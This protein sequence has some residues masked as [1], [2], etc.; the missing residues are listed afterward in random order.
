MPFRDLGIDIDYTGRGDDILRGFVLPVLA[1]AI[2]YDRVTSFFSTQSLIAIAAGLDSLWHRHGRMRLVL[3]IHNVPADL[4]HAARKAE[5]PTVLIISQVRQ[6]IIEGIATISDELSIDRL[7]TVAWMMKDSLLSVKV[8]SP[9]RFGLDSPGLFH[10]KVFIFRDDNGDVVA[11]VGSPN[12]TGAGLG[13]NFEHLTAFTSWEQAR[14]TN[15]QVNFFERLWANEQDGLKVHLLDAT[16]ADQILEA[17][18]KARPDFYYSSVCKEKTIRKLLDVASRM[19]ALSMVAGG[20]TALYPHQELVFLDGLSRWPVRLMLADEV[21]LGKTFEAGAILSYMISH[22]GIN[23]ILVLAPK[24]VVFQWQAELN[25]HFGLDSWVYESGRRAFVSPNDEVVFLGADDPIL[26]PRTPRIV[27]V[28]SQLARGTR[29]QGHIFEN[30]SVLPDMMVV[31]EAHAARVKPDLAGDERPTLLWKMLADVVQKVPHIVFATAT[32]MQVHWREYHALLE[33]LG[34]PDEWLK[35]KQYHRSLE[36]TTRLD[37][38]DLSEASL[39]ARLIRASLNGYRPSELSLSQEE[40]TLA[41]F[42]QESDTQTVEVAIRV[43]REWN[44]ARALLVKTHPA[45]FLTLRNTRTALEAIDYTFPKRNLPPFSLDVPDEVK[46]FY[47]KVE[48]YLSEVYFEV[49]RAL[50]PDRKFS[51][52]F[53]KCAYQQRLASSLSACR[54]SLIHRRDRVFEIEKGSANEIFLE[55]ELDELTESDAFDQDFSFDHSINAADGANLEQAIQSARIERLFLDD[56]IRILD[57][58]I[59]EHGDP[60]MR[61]TVGLLHQHLERGDKVLVFSRYTDTLD[62]VV[63]AFCAAFVDRCPPYAV[64]TG[65]STGIDFG[66][67]PARATRGEIRDA[68]EEGAVSVVFC[69]DAASEGLNLQA[70]R[71]IVNVD[72]PWN[73][74][75]LEQRIGRIARLGQAA[76]SVDIYN[77]W[78]PESIESKMYSRL[79]QRTDLFELAVGEFPDV[80]GSAIR[81]ELASRFGVESDAHDVISE[82]NALKNDE[83]IRALK[84]LWDRDL[85]KTTLTGRFRNELACL[86]ISAARSAGASISQS[87]SVFRII[88]GNDTIT[89]SVEPGR[90]DVI[91]LTHPALRWLERLENQHLRIVKILSDAHGPKFF[92]KENEPV[93]PTTVTGLF[94]LA[95]GQ[96]IDGYISEIQFSFSS[97]GRYNPQS[98]AASSPSDDSSGTAGV[99]ST[100]ATASRLSIN[101]SIRTDVGGGIEGAS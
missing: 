56:L 90:N 47:Q 92:V 32:P 36:L 48:K 25:E 35:P 55:Q 46:V 30:A 31:D 43:K 28:S 59:S 51:I 101:A 6:R 41:H 8:A 69:S 23:R 71:V 17:I 52:G 26:G 86:A 68:L 39:V 94:H 16:F 89:F 18:S 73:P 64:Y 98:M 5:D 84:T 2:E 10:N 61:G 22:A 85:E 53:V 3:G 93:N 87:G 11:A 78:Y 29:R 24:A 45:R 82:L 63:R 80:V 72:V 7:S 40:Q 97:A 15:S 65:S 37:S 20:H 81:D 95:S 54:L 100:R 14:Y 88:H 38:I 75:R 77:L 44:A 76:P 1:E 67:G 99:S 12:E 79:M 74:A 27:I 91:S 19:P 33:L 57:R 21:G 66:T 62:A 58:V 60:K 83:Q 70:A 9:D 42:I 49:E 96:N 13:Q 50:F 34:L 4:A